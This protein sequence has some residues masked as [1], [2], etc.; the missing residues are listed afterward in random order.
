MAR[1]PD[2][3]CG[4]RTGRKATPT[5]AGPATRLR[6]AT[7]VVVA[8]W[9]MAALALAGP[10]T[11]ARAQVSDA[12]GADGF[13]AAGSGAVSFVSEGSASW[14]TV[15]LADGTTA[16]LDGTVQF[17]TGFA[18][19]AAFGAYYGD[20]RIE[21]ELGYSTTTIDSATAS[22]SAGNAADVGLSIDID[23]YAAGTNFFF[24]WPIEYQGLRPYA[25]IGIGYTAVSAGSVEGSVNAVALDFPDPTSDG[26]LTFRG[27]LGVQ[28]P[29]DDL[30]TVTADYRYEDTSDFGF[31]S[32]NGSISA[33]SSAHQVGVGVRYN[34]SVPDDPMRKP[35]QSTRGPETGA[36][37]GDDGQPLPQGLPRATPPEP[38]GS[39]DEPGRAALVAATPA[40]PEKPPPAGTSPGADPQASQISRPEDARTDRQGSRSAGPALTAVELS[41]TQGTPVRSAAPLQLV[42]ARRLVDQGPVAGMRPPR[43]PLPSTPVEAAAA[44][45]RASAGRLPLPA[46][47]Q[48]GAV[49]LEPVPGRL[50]WAPDADRRLPLPDQPE[51][52]SGVGSQFGVYLGRFLSPEEARTF[53]DWL[54]SVPGRLG[55]LTPQTLY[56]RHEPAFDGGIYDLFGARLTAE[57][58][59]DLCLSLFVLRIGCQVRLLKNRDQP[60][61]STDENGGGSV[62][63]TGHGNALPQRSA[64]AT[65]GSPDAAQQ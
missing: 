14:R 28:Y 24:D 54:Q 45:R 46:R 35:R 13:Y 7:A 22:T 23:R 12:I 44:S 47:S 50:A 11:T 20:F 49:L 58:A 4:N 59:N 18:A 52:S 15:S 5:A 41:R 51:S 57:Q 39:E 16:S 48:A 6:G 43:S 2:R 27:M 25:G 64:T 19:R 38:E 42:S 61:P 1:K 3:D 29:V 34:F 55:P 32:G 53:V 9:V 40:D 56:L 31:A 30:I 62:S 37:L 60:G 26:Q 17:S 21:L 36:V 8:P 10:G 63:G 65:S 33:E